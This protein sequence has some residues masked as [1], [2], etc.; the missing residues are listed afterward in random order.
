MV[1]HGYQP[2]DSLDEQAKTVDNQIDVVT[3]AFLGL[4]VACARCHDH[5]F[6]AVGQRDYYAPCT[7]SSRP[8]GRR[9]VTIDDPAP[10]RVKAA[11]LTAA[12]ARIKAR[13]AE[14]WAADAD[15]FARRLPAAHAS[16][17]AGLARLER[18]LADLDRQARDAA[19]KARG[20]AAPAPGGP[21]PLAAWR[22]DGDARD[23]AGG[24]HG[25]LVAGAAVRGG[26]LVLD[27]KGAFVRTSPLTRAVREK[28]LEAWVSPA[29]LDQAGG[30][31]LSLETKS[32]AVFDALVFGEKRP[33]RW[34][35]GSN[36][37][38]RTRDVDGPAESASRAGPSTWRPPT[39][40]TARSRCSATAKPTAGPTRRTAP[41]PS[42]RATRGS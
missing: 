23:A 17:S 3:K 25:E 2:V 29:R 35:A 33:G 39:P 5:K 21:R 22:F 38:R 32:G 16:T 10:L 24:L 37:F 30:G 31:G 18:R 28:T 7:A 15:A 20:V 27:G 36:N 8:A 1:E 34:I 42:R 40:P 9:Q 41:S 26:R 19:L 11:E 12:K 4:T 14:A 13:L 6:D